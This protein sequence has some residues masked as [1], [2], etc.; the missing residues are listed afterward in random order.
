[1]IILK[2]ASNL[3]SLMRHGIQIQDITLLFHDEKVFQYIKLI[4]KAH[5]PVIWKS[6]KIY[7]RVI[8]VIDSE[9]KWWQLLDRVISLPVQAEYWFID[10]FSSVNY[11]ISAY[12]GRKEE[13]RLKE[14]RINVESNL[15]RW[16]DFIKEQYEVKPVEVIRWLRDVDFQKTV[17]PIHFQILLR[18]WRQWTTHL[19]YRKCIIEIL[20]HLP[21]YEIPIYQ[22]WESYYDY[23]HPVE[24]KDFLREMVMLIE[25]TFPNVRWEGDIVEEKSLYLFR[26]WR[27][28]YWGNKPS[29]SK[30]TVIR[31]AVSP[32]CYPK[33]HRCLLERVFWDQFV[34]QPWMEF[35]QVA[36]LGETSPDIIFISSPVESCPRY[37]Q[38]V[39][40]VLDFD[41]LL[42]KNLFVPNTIIFRYQQSNQIEHHQNTV[43]LPLSINRDFLVRYRRWQVEQWNWKM[44]KQFGILVIG[45]WDKIHHLQTDPGKT[46]YWFK[47]QPFMTYG[48]SS[49]IKSSGQHILVESY[50]DLEWVLPRVSQV[51]LMEHITLLSPLEQW[52]LLASGI[53]TMEDRKMLSPNWESCQWSLITFLT[54]VSFGNKFQ[55]IFCWDWLWSKVQPLTPISVLWVDYGDIVW[56]DLQ[57]NHFE[58]WGI[59]QDIWRGLMNQLTNSRRQSVLL[60][61]W[62]LSSG[63]REKDICV[64]K[65][66]EEE[67][68]DIVVRLRD[69]YDKRW[70]FMSRYWGNKKVKQVLGDW[71]EDKNYLNVGRDGSGIKIVDH[72]DEEVALIRKKSECMY[73]MNRTDFTE[74][75][76]NRM[77]LSRKCLTYVV[78]DLLPEIKGTRWYYGGTNMRP[79]RLGK[80][81]TIESYQAMYPQVE[82]YRVEQEEEWRGVDFVLNIDTPWVLYVSLALGLPFITTRTGI[83]SDIENFCERRG[84]DLP[85][86]IM[87][88]DLGEI[89]PQLTIQE[90]RHRSEM[91]SICVRGHWSNEFS[92]LTWLQGIPMPML[93]VSLLIPYYEVVSSVMEECLRSI[94]YQV[95]LGTHVRLEVLMLNNGNPEMFYHRTMIDSYRKKWDLE[96]R[97]IDFYQNFDEMF[98]LSEGER[99]AKYN[100]ILIMSPN[101][102]MSNYRLWAQSKKVYENKDYI[103]EG[104]IYEDGEIRPGGLIT[105]GYWR[106]IENQQTKMVNEI[107]GWKQ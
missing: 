100:C 45:R 107:Y 63:Y 69:I 36:W 101:F 80:I 38:C 47:H 39:R 78:Y 91:A 50:S 8:I 61:L 104:H 31:Y 29:K 27:E 51:I 32:K 99:E 98:V 96:V 28:Y 55:D 2:M 41:N 53:F 81:G 85:G 33:S 105:R 12:Q 3:L 49:S 4:L 21:F 11:W 106:G 94:E 15:F 76:K 93:E 14:T 66:K 95:G 60:W 54:A 58:N 102:V 86:W 67:K 83:A 34:N 72:L 37:V 52:I 77:Y 18:F 35:E 74:C 73:V 90:V 5:N 44:R 19:V 42:D 9:S 1:V 88:N 97:I 23:A 16:V 56:T 25:D 64:K 17:L 82:F 43:Y 79:Y 68:P 70:V 59:R 46:Y 65:V 22:L 57:R 7:G 6:G 26:Q 87:E 30:E 84:I 75:F 89:I 103:Y 10:S 13:S 62:Y 24:W 92:S 20:K 48:S 40:I 71:V